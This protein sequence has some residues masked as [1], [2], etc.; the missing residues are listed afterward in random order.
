MSFDQITAQMDRRHWWLVSK[1]QESFGDYLRSAVL[2]QFLSHPDTLP[3]LLR[4]TAPPSQNPPPALFVWIPANMVTQEG[5]IMYEGDDQEFSVGHS[6][7]SEFLLKCVYFIRTKPHE[8]IANE[9]AGTSEVGSSARPQ[10][11]RSSGKPRSGRSDVASTGL[12]G[13]HDGDGDTESV[14]SIGMVDDDEGDGDSESAGDRGSGEHGPGD[15]ATDDGDGLGGGDHDTG[16]LEPHRRARFAPRLSVAVQPALEEGRQDEVESEDG[17]MA[18]IVD[19]DAEDPFQDSELFPKLVVWGELEPNVANEVRSAYNSVLTPYL[20]FAEWHECTTEQQQQLKQAIDKLLSSLNT[21]EAALHMRTVCLSIPPMYAFG[22]FRPGN[23]AV[24][25]ETLKQAEGIVDGWIEAIDDL[26][27]EGAFEHPPHYKGVLGELEFWKDRQLALGSVTD[28][29]KTRARQGIISVLISSQSKVVRRWRSTDGAITEATNECKDY[30]K[31]LDNIRPLLQDLSK[32]DPEAVLASL[33]AMSS[34][35]KPSGTVVRHINAAVF[36]QSFFSRIS[37]EV[38]RSL[39]CFLCPR[40]EEQKQL[41]FWPEAAD[42]EDTPYQPI[43]LAKDD[44]GEPSVIVSKEVIEKLRRCKRVVKFYLDTFEPMLA[45]RLL[46]RAHRRGTVDSSTPRP[47]DGGRVSTMLHDRPSRTSRTSRIDSDSSRRDSSFSAISS[48]LS[49]RSGEGAKLPPVIFMRAQAFLQRLRELVHIFT[50]LHTLEEMKKAMSG[51][52]LFPEHARLARDVV[53]IKKFLLDSGDCLHNLEPGDFFSQG[54]QAMADLVAASTM[55]LSTALTSGMERAPSTMEAIAYINKFKTILDTKESMAS[56]VNA[57]IMQLFIEYEGELEQLQAQFEQHKADPPLPRCLPPTVGHIVWTRHLLHRMEPPM[58]FFKSHTEVI[59]AAGPAAHTIRLYN[60]LSKA[61]LTYETMYFTKWKASV[62]G[63]LSGLKATLLVEHPTTR[64]LVLNADP[65]VFTLLDEAKIMTRERISIPNSLNGVLAQAEKFKSFA[66]Q[67]QNI[68]NRHHRIVTSIPSY[69]APLLKLPISAVMRAFRPGLISLTWDASNIDAYTARIGAGL[70]LLD[71]TTSRVNHVIDETVKQI[72]TDIRQQQLVLSSIP[73]DV[74]TLDE[75]AHSQTKAL[76]AGTSRLAASIEEVM[77]CVDAIFLLA[78]ES[79][80]ATYRLPFFKHDDE[81]TAHT[82]CPAAKVDL[83]KQFV[84]MVEDALQA[85]LVKAIRQIST[86]LST[87]RNLPADDTEKP[88]SCILLQVERASPHLVQLP[89]SSQ[90]SDKLGELTKDLQSACQAL[91]AAL[92]DSANNLNAVRRPH[93]PAGRSPD[94]RRAKSGAAH[95]S[96]NHHDSTHATR[97]KQTLSGQRAPIKLHLQARALARME[98]VVEARAAVDALIQKLV[99]VAGERVHALDSHTWEW[100]RKSSRRATLIIKRSS[101]VQLHKD[102]EAR[103]AFEQLQS[104]L[105]QLIDIEQAIHEIEAYICV[106]GPF[107]LGTRN[108]K[109]ALLA[110]ATAWKAEHAAALHRAASFELERIASVVKGLREQMDSEIE[111]LDDLR[112]MIEVLGSVDQHSQD[113]DASALERVFEVLHEIGLT[114]PRHEVQALR[115]LKEQCLDITDTARRVTHDLTTTRRPEFERLLDTQAK[116]LMVA[117][118]HLR[119]SFDNSGP[120]IEG[121]T[122][123]E[124]LMRLRR[125]TSLHQQLEDERKTLAAVE[126]LLGFPPTPYPELDRTRKDLQRLDSLYGLYE[127]FV[128]HQQVF[129]ETYWTEADLQATETELRGFSTALQGLS[130]SLKKWQAY[131]EMQHTVSAQLEVLPLLH[132]LALPSIRDRHWREVMHMTGITFPLEG[133]TIRK[134]LSL[135]LLKYANKIQELARSATG[136]AELEKSLNKIQ[137]EWSDHVFPM[138]A[139]AEQKSVLLLDVDAT[140]NLITSAQESHMQLHTMLSSP[141]LGPHRTDLVAWLAK[142]RE[143]SVFLTKWLEVQKLWGELEVMTN[144]P[145]LSQQSKRLHSVARDLYKFGLAAQE[146][147]NILQFCFGGDGEGAKTALLSSFYDRLEDCRKS[148]S[149]FLNKKREAFPRFYFLSDMMLLRALGT[150]LG[151]GTQVVLPEAIKTLIPAIRAFQIADERL[152]QQRPYSPSLPKVKEEGTHERDNSH[153]GM[154]GLAA[155]G[156]SPGSDDDEDEDVSH[157]II[158]RLISRHGEEFD[159][160]SAVRVTADVTTWLSALLSQISRSLRD[161]ILGACTGLPESVATL[162]DTIRTPLDQTAPKRA[163]SASGG[164]NGS[165]PGSVDRSRPPSS[166]MRNPPTNLATTGYQK[167]RTI[168]EN[169][170]PLQSAETEVNQV[171]ILATRLYWTSTMALGIDQVR[172]NRFALR[173]AQHDIVTWCNKMVT[174]GMVKKKIKKSQLAQL[175]Y[176]TV[177]TLLLHLRDLS[178]EILNARCRDLSDFAWLKQLR[179]YLNPEKST[180]QVNTLYTSLC[181]GTEYVGI[182]QPVHI[183]SLMDKYHTMLMQ[184]LVHGGGLYSTPMPAVSAPAH[185][186]KQTVVRALS[187]M[188]GRNLF[189]LDCTAATD[190]ASVQRIVKGLCLSRSWGL[191][192]ELTQ[193]S[194]ECLSVAVQHIRL[195]HLHLESDPAFAAVMQQRAGTASTSQESLKSADDVVEFAMFATLS[196]TSSRPIPETVR[197]CFRV[198]EVSRPSFNI[199]VYAHCL[200]GGM[201]TNPKSVAEKT[202]KLFQITAE[203]F[204]NR[205]WLDFG[206]ES[207]KTVLQES[208]KFR[209]ASSTVTVTGTNVKAPGMRPKP[210]SRRESRGQAQAHAHSRTARTRESNAA[211]SAEDLELLTI[212]LAFVDM[213][214]S[215]LPEDDQ[216]TLLEIATSVVPGLQSVRRRRVDA[217]EEDQLSEAITKCADRIGLVAESSWVNFALNIHH[218]SRNNRTVFVVGPAGSGKTTALRGLIAG[219]NKVTQE[220]ND[221]DMA[222]AS[223]V[224]LTSIDEYSQADVSCINSAGGHG[225]KERPLHREHRLY[226]AAIGTKQLF[227]FAPSKDEWVDGIVPMLL[228][229]AASESGKHTIHWIVFDGPCDNAWAHFLRRCLGNSPNSYFPC[230]NGDKI[231]VPSNIKFVFEL[232]P[233]QSDQASL[234]APASS[235]AFLTAPCMSWRALVKPWLS[236]RRTPEAELLQPLFDRYMGTMLEV[237]STI[238]DH[239]MQVSM[240]CRVR[241]TLDLLSALLSDSVNAAI[242][243]PPIHVECAFLFAITWGLG[244]TLEIQG[245]KLFH[246]ELGKLSSLIPNDNDELTMFDYCLSPSADWETW[247]DFAE[248]MEQDAANLTGGDAEQPFVF[249]KEMTCATFLLDSLTQSGTDANAIIVGHSGVGRSALLQQMLHRQR[250]LSVVRNMPVS[251]Q[252]DAC[253]VQEYMSRF[254]SR[255]TGHVYGAEGGKPLLLLVDDIDACTS[256][257]P[258]A[259]ATAAEQ[260]GASRTGDSTMHAHEVLRLLLEE[261]SWYP[262]AS[263]SGGAVDSPAS[264]ETARMRREACW[265]TDLSVIATCQ[266]QYAR[267]TTLSRLG[268]HMAVFYV[269]PPSQPSSIAILTA[270]PLAEQFSG[271]QDVEVRVED[272]NG[273][274]TGNNNDDDGGT[275]WSKGDQEYFQNMMT[276]EMLAE[277][278]HELLTD[279]NKVLKPTK[280]ELYHY[281]FNLRDAVTVMRGLRRC[282]PSEHSTHVLCAFW[283]SECL[284]VFGDRMVCEEHRDMLRERL[285]T[286]LR[287]REES[288]A[289]V[290]ANHQPLLLS[291]DT[292][293][294]WDDTLPCM[295]R[296][297]KALELHGMCLQDVFARLVPPSAHLSVATVPLDRFVDDVCSMCEGRVASKEL[298]E[299]VAPLA[300]ANATIDQSAIVRLMDV[301]A[302][303][304]EPREDE[305]SL[306]ATGRT[307]GLPGLQVVGEHDA[308]TEEEEAAML[309]M[310]QQGFATAHG[311]SGGVGGADAPAAWPTWFADFGSAVFMPRSKI[312]NTAGNKLQ[313]TQQR[314]STVPDFHEPV[315]VT[316]LAFPSFRASVLSVLLEEKRHHRQRVDLSHLHK[317]T[318]NLVAALARVL[319]MTHS[320][321]IFVVPTGGGLTDALNVATRLVNYRLMPLHSHNLRTFHNDM[322]AVYRLAGSKNQPVCCVLEGEHMV[323][324]VMDHISSFILTGSI[325]NLFAA[326]EEAALYDGVVAD[327]AKRAS[328]GQSPAQFFHQRLQHNVHLIFRF[329][330]VG[331]RLKLLSGSFP[332]ILRRCY[333]YHSLPMTPRMAS[334][335][336]T[337]ALFAKPMLRSFSCADVMRIVTG[338]T[339]IHDRLQHLDIA[340]LAELSQSVD[341]SNKLGDSSRLDLFAVL[342]KMVNFFCVIFTEKRRQQREEQRRLERVLANCAATDEYIRSI[343]KSAAENAERIR[344]LDQKVQEALVALSDA[345]AGEISQMTDEGLESDDDEELLTNF[346]NQKKRE[347]R[348]MASSKVST[349]ETMRE[350]RV[351]AALDDVEMWQ[352]KLTLKRLDNLRSLTNPPQL[353][354]LVADMIMVVLKQPL[355]NDTSRRRG[356]SLFA[357]N[358]ETTTAHMQS[359]SI[360]AKLQQFNPDMLDHETVELLD[361]FLQ[362]PNLTPASVKRA[363]KDA[364]VL[365]E[366]ML[367]LME[368]HR[369]RCMTSGQQKYISGSIVVTHAGS[370]QKHIAV[371]SETTPGGLIAITEDQ[372]AEEE[373]EQENPSPA[374]APATAGQDLSSSTK[375]K[376]PKDAVD[377]TGLDVIISSENIAQLQR[378]YDELVLQKQRCEETAKVLQ[379]RLQAASK[380]RKSFTSHLPKWTGELETLKNGG[381]NCVRNSIVSAAFAAFAGNL[382]YG[383]QEAVRKALLEETVAFI[384]DDR[385][386]RAPVPPVTKSGRRRSPHLRRKL[387]ANNDL[388]P[389]AST[390]AATSQA[391][392]RPRRFSRAQSFNSNTPPAVPKSPPVKRLPRLS[393]IMRSSSPEDDVESSAKGGSKSPHCRMLP[394]V[395]ENCDLAAFLGLD[396]TMHPKELEE[397]LTSK[398][399][400]P[401]DGKTLIRLALSVGWTTYWPVVYDPCGLVGAWIVGE[402]HA[403]APGAGDGGKGAAGAGKAAPRSGSTAVTTA[404]AAAAAGAATTAA[405]ARGGTGQGGHASSSS[406]AA[407]AGPARTSLHHEGSAVR[408]DKHRV[409]PL[410]RLPQARVV[411]ASCYH[412]NVTDV[413]KTAVAQG[414]VLVLEDVDDQFWTDSRF[415]P[416]LRRRRNKTSQGHEAVYID[417]SPVEWHPRFRLIFTSRQPLVVPSD[418]IMDLM[419]VSFCPSV[420]E[421]ET[422]V[423]AKTVSFKQPSLYST[424]QRT[425]ETLRAEVVEMKQL[426][427]KLLQLLERSDELD[428]DGKPSHDDLSWADEILKTHNALDAV[429][430]RSLQ[431]ARDLNTIRGE[432]RHCEEAACVLSRLTE[433]IGLLMAFE[434]STLVFDKIE[435]VFDHTISAA[436]ASPNFSM[437]ALCTSFIDA[438]HTILGKEISELGRELLQLI[439][440]MQVDA[441][442][443][444]ES[445]SALPARSLYQWF[446][447]PSTVSFDDWAQMDAGIA[448]D[449]ASGAMPLA[450]VRARGIQIEAKLQALFERLDST[451]WLKVLLNYGEAIARHRSDWSQWRELNCPEAAPTFPASCSAAHRDHFLVTTALRNDR[452]LAASRMWLSST[453]DASMSPFYQR[454]QFWTEVADGSNAQPALVAFEDAAGQMFLTGE[455]RRFCDRERLD[456]TVVM[457]HERQDAH[458]L[459]SYVEM[460]QESGSWLVLVNIEA[461]PALASKLVHD[462]IYAND[463][464]VHQKFRLVCMYNNRKFCPQ[465]IITKSARLCVCN[466]SSFRNKLAT[467]LAQ[468]PSDIVLCSTRSDWPYLLHNL[469]FFHCVM[470]FRTHFG[471]PAWSH[472]YNWPDSVLADVMEFAGRQFLDT[473]SSHRLTA[474]KHYVELVYGSQMSSTRDKRILL[475]LMSTY[476]T[477]SAIKPDFHLTTIPVH[478]SSE[479]L[480][481]YRVPMPSQRRTR[482]TLMVDLAENVSKSTAL[483]D[484][485]LPIICHVPGLA[486]ELP[487][488]ALNNS[489]LQIMRRLVGRLDVMGA[490]SNILEASPPE[491]PPIFSPTSPRSKRRSTVRH[492]SRLKR[493][494][495]WAS[496]EF[497]HT[498]PPYRPEVLHR[499]MHALP[500]LPSASRIAKKLEGSGTPHGIA[501]FLTDQT[502]ELRQL[503]GVVLSRLLELDDF[504]QGWGRPNPVYASELATINEGQVPDTWLRLL[505]LPTT[506]PLNNSQLQTWLD[507]VTSRARDVERAA[508][509]GSRALSIGL[510][511]FP[512]PKAFFTALRIQGISTFGDDAAFCAEV[513]NRE[514]EHLREP[515][516]DGF[517]IH[518]AALQG[519]GWDSGEAKDSAKFQ[520]SPLPVLHVFY[521]PPKQDSRSQEDKGNKLR[522]ARN[523]ADTKRKGVFR[524]PVYHL[525]DEPE[526][527]ELTPMFTVSIPTEDVELNSSWT[528]RGVCVTLL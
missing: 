463:R 207:L 95:R 16:H 365:L 28:Q 331:H 379:Q 515:P 503:F 59:Q 138:E 501:R 441:S 519:C 318:L 169:F 371:P 377:T 33:Q 474:I 409:S 245:R 439:I 154:A 53:A 526:G 258:P 129:L 75:F 191:L 246:T 494:P 262:H 30:I 18:G 435:D 221:K 82:A 482:S 368:Y 26:L 348:R 177:V 210:P 338:I 11:A 58:M 6:P 193:L 383:Q 219:L 353:V 243:L 291:T 232:T 523:D 27:Q 413:V 364:H 462:N 454:S 337:A 44:H 161:K 4:F 507:F 381:W 374:E 333:V 229:Q 167:P 290:P 313:R 481:P 461:N 133:L 330:N 76:Q 180:A 288:L 116:A 153:P 224:S 186:G 350:Q 428:A 522:P 284:R 131:K 158:T 195:L 128:A 276:M 123:Q 13:R 385:K 238:E 87:K 415:F 432:F 388:D 367:H 281:V 513:S 447:R 431:T 223:K 306:A 38:S 391:G 65:A 285:N 417:G 24:D 433:G 242:I 121:I 237:V 2:E 174:A 520:R 396:H 263:S 489:V 389:R 85:C 203:A 35:A 488:T 408:N 448:V 99:A 394:K 434:R 317:E 312:T 185:T 132:L 326:E 322:R 211:H 20:H 310:V 248:E 369:V 457:V 518:G 453:L 139:P 9:V 372:N 254:T 299:E 419:P 91:C 509:S 329:Q 32:Q 68:L 86:L 77:R 418:L 357:D 264:S 127:R 319:N 508:Y 51:C 352:S 327:A 160:S 15:A 41:V 171:S 190:A 257:H 354:K 220:K 88:S 214:H 472:R 259:I 311:G 189:Q 427:S 336:T 297:S 466:V 506:M 39:A 524:C 356:T 400:A 46:G 111:S 387:T 302:A 401:A 218:A 305:G 244:G 222:A 43:W 270:A 60:K 66:E 335:I 42:D 460:A 61:L 459:E 314:N 78:R 444:V 436:F 1:M 250:H 495:L 40:A 69:V 34:S 102:A 56:S 62:S 194:H 145:E 206:L 260:E 97:S 425:Q 407:G 451:P 29:L 269:P 178:D 351:L 5:P 45:R 527:G 176:Q 146:T 343:R 175:K 406:A 126:A 411:S 63:M 380:R 325:F 324:E 442:L 455:V 141:S 271:G 256:S 64:R 12:G 55:Y 362:L 309:A 452:L 115:E 366:W 183:G 483:D 22:L 445:E 152:M 164:H 37:E 155:R 332:N 14:D 405:K 134:V 528:L 7:P 286:L 228:R 165:R 197:A 196:T 227:G 492:S 236:T 301:A 510:G 57:A 295:V 49:E 10:D 105:H 467:L 157:L 19:D 360:L 98:D 386:S 373:E 137:T 273:E 104:D 484:S 293:N 279:L 25:P 265:I 201:F 79:E 122:P 168:G 361:V 370:G 182:P 118:I 289:P 378:A 500:I 151:A 198:V 135:R 287:Q 449:R 8:D 292:A 147:G 136:E 96:H 458:E 199:I 382:T 347:R 50:E 403:T 416:L 359:P 112:V 339:R 235:A 464:E 496:E 202:V 163:S 300:R 275:G 341:E 23:R 266:P 393:R 261:G 498:C 446:H 74:T 294:T 321:G 328:P 241:T 340:P 92:I 159:L 376:R 272:E 307:S 525:L 443:G 517:L 344:T 253:T 100:E 255:R 3:A 429:T 150:Q 36:F 184:V 240:T 71:H 83:I 505:P 234:F 479:T 491:K 205:P 395:F 247:E 188:L 170:S 208:S 249:T 345:A 437:T 469:A 473:S 89:S 282:P 225:N 402:L 114:L 166:S 410:I 480:K 421:H 397:E 94:V 486:I 239:V 487:S 358:W 231:R 31:F 426:E 280:P 423:Y 412:P 117:T 156:D 200:S 499:I 70:D 48:A 212:A 392:P 514:R 316:P 277:A 52:I 93:A 125:L 120:T 512:S 456:C 398:L 475:T 470:N 355:D 80:D 172:V 67:L 54:Y 422:C 497:G 142:L 303:E 144:V 476:I 108:L 399:Q 490:H 148:I 278:T 323:P 81:A 233:E 485:L 162:D 192:S 346:V 73:Q 21:F 315:P 143:I 478:M 215:C 267:K 268:R 124:A 298:K 17:T 72:L 130:P 390:T 465:H 226:P 106:G 468:I 430:E 209:D 140:Q 216:R 274:A 109:L 90:L 438:V 149:L 320:H 113:L 187:N 119:N 334:N 404:A 308:E 384:A 304:M 173:S 516:G 217:E 349:N 375:R 204:S 283:V 107:C 440:I 110:E 101:L 450:D 230:G 414:L 363:S 420:M 47:S 252:T 504:C 342:H 84:E 511:S 477:S 471:L 181:Y 213:Y 251:G 296:A 502:E 179:W 103:E 493:T 424:L 521:A